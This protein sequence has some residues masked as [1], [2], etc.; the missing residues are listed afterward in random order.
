MVAAAAALVLEEHP[1]YSPDDV[2]WTLEQDG[3]EAAD[4]RRAGAGSRHRRPPQGRASTSIP[5]GA[6]TTQRWAPSTGTG[7]LDAA[8]GTYR[9]TRDGVVLDGERD[10]FG[11]PWDGVSWSG[12]SWSGVSWSGGDWNGV[13]WSGA[14]WGGVSWSGVSWSGV[15]WSGVS[16]SGVSWS[17]VSWSGVSLVRRV[18]VR[19]QLVRRVL[20]R[21]VVVV[22][23]R[24]LIR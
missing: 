14:G 3:Q 1:S 2:K 17:G 13:S 19:R 6:D 22:A 11:T 4:G 23:Q 24:G 8:R 21:R 20:V 10:I 16:W 18:L 15:S 9:L 5:G 12:V 7:S